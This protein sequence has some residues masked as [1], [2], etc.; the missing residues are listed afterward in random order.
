MSEPFYNA[1][2]GILDSGHGENQKS[3]K[4][5]KEAFEFVNWYL[6]QRRNGKINELFATIH[7]T[8]HC[9]DLSPKLVYKFE[10]GKGAVYTGSKGR[11]STLS[12]PWRTLAEKHGG[13]DGLAGEFGVGIATVYRWAGNRS[14][15][16]PIFAKKFEELKKNLD[17][18]KSD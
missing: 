12:E 17:E 14:Q 8:A 6:S 11:P 3:F 16:L 4:T 5:Y 2:V 15:M 9:N 13:M 1:Y 10:D 7:E 18:R